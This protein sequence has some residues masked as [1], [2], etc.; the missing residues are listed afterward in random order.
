MDKIIIKGLKIFAHHGVHD[1]EKQNGQT[2]ILDIEMLADLQKPCHSDKLEDTLN[3]S[4]A[5]KTVEHIMCEKSYDLIERAAQAVADAL[6]EE[7]AAVQNVHVVLKKPQAP[8]NA[9]FDYVAADIVRS[10][11]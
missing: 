1:F 11:R 10:R 9:E 2:F 5:V 4:L 3:Y 6:F 8:I 7:F